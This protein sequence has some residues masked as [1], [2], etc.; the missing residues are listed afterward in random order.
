VPPPSEPFTG[1]LNGNNFTISN[2]IID[3]AT[4]DYQALFGFVETNNTVI[5]NLNVTECLVKGKR[6]TSC[7]VALQTGGVIDNCTVSGSVSGTAAYAGGITAKM[8]DSAEIHNCSSAVDV[9]NTSATT[10][11]IAGGIMNSSIIKNCYA[12]GTI[13][14]TNYIG[15][16]TGYMTDS[17]MENCYSTGDVT[18]E[19]MVGGLIGVVGGISAVKT[20][21]ATGNVTGTVIHTGG[22]IGQSATSLT[23][24]DCYATGDVTGIENT[25]SFIGNNN[26]PGTI[27]NCYSRGDVIRSSGIATTFGGFAGKNTGTITGAYYCGNLS[28]GLSDNAFGARRT[29][30][31]MKLIDTS[32]LTYDG[33]DFGSIWAIDPSKN[34]NFPYLLSNPS[35]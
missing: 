6:Y 9:N 23:I 4:E 12:T 35:P 15:G 19:R 22:L 31:Q 2:L 34:Q 13:N 32:V 16:I 14:G 10:G 20:C 7:L 29:A 21:Y 24:S 25:G 1:I 5:K 28:T 8:T 27:N 33:W 30:D 18:G 11:G 26:T 17:S 3:N